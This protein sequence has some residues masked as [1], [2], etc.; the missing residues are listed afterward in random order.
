MF[1]LPPPPPAE[2]VLTGA[3]VWFHDGGL[4]PAQAVVVRGGR[5]ADVG[6]EAEILKAHPTARKVALS[7]GTLLPAFIEGHAHVEGVG[8]LRSQVSLTGADSLEEVRRR[9]KA[10]AAGS[11]SPWIQGR[12][13]DQNL[14]PSKAFPHAKDLDAA[15]GNRPA[16]LRRVDGHAV[17]ANSAA[18]KL[19]GITDRTPDPVGGRIVRDAEG[20]ATGVFI[21]AASQLLLKHIPAPNLQERQEILRQGLLALRELGFAS[22][23][24]MG[25]DGTA[26]QAYRN[27]AHTGSLPIRVFAYLAD[28]PVL[29]ARELARPR[30]AALSFFQVQGA[31]Q[32][33]DGALGSRGARML[34]P[35]A[36][37]PG[38]QGLWVMSPAHVAQVLAQT[39]KQGYQLAVHCIGDAANRA[40]LD[41]V[42]KAGPH[43]GLPIRN[44]H[45][46]IVAPEDARRF[47]ALGLVASAQPIHLADDH[48][49]TP[50]RLGPE[51]TPE[52]FPWRTFLKHGATLCF[53][54]DAPVADANPFLGLSAAETRQDAQGRPQGGFLPE[55]CL[56]R[57]E[58]LKAY[59]EANGRVLGHPDLGVIRKG[60]VADLLW[61]EAPVLSVSPDR[62]RAL[63]PTRMW[64]DGME[65]S[66]PSAGAPT[67][68]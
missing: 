50:A 36:D 68:R 35:Y 67:T 65:V 42:V 54:S 26:L 25:I 2:V 23:A 14:W 22:V 44:E 4:K 63:R 38:T 52:A 17:W 24:D 53:G 64:V 13:W 1:A 15:T 51:R 47:G 18:L 58:A 49:W 19:A 9:V 40:L 37:E 41:L 39:R 20:H 29:L 66:A 46:Q 30:S 56:T 31:K 8:L 45:S 61:V 57:A 62:L 48:A 12:G 55:H 16:A 7:G 10:Y 60:A 32:M 5:I 28:E 27:L 3:D 11:R 59:T 34:A 43:A 6:A 21:D 33:L